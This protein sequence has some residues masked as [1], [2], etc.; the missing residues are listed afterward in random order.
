MNCEY[1]HR[2][3]AAKLYK[4]Y[5]EIIGTLVGMIN[6]PDSWIIQKKK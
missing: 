3:S 2:D 4:T 5:D 6:H 1:A